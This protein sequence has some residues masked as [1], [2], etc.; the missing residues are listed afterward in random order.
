[1]DC[2]PP[3]RSADGKIVLNHLHWCPGE[4]K[5]GDASGIMNLLDWFKL[6]SSE[7]S[8]LVEDP[9]YDPRN[10]KVWLSLPLSPFLVLFLFFL[11][12]ISSPG[13][14]AESPRN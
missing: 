4:S 7:I 6:S 3:T 9:S 2:R 14:L 5:D 10:G 11:L 12:Y 8:M 1:M 13:V